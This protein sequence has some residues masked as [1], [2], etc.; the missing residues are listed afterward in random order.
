MAREHLT[1][2]RA[3]VTVLL[4]GVYYCDTVTGGSMRFPE[5]ASEE[6]S[7][8]G[9][10][11]DE[12]LS[13]SRAGRNLRLSVGGKDLVEPLA[14]GSDP[15]FK[16]LSAGPGKETEARSYVASKLCSLGLAKCGEERHG[17]GSGGQYGL[18]NIRDVTLV[19][20]VALRPVGEPI[21]AI[22]LEKQPFAPTT[23][24][25]KYM[26]SGFGNYGSENQNFPNYNSQQGG[27][28][29]SSHQDCT[30]VSINQCN[31]YDIINNQV[32]SGTGNLGVISGIGQPH[33]GNV[34]AGIDPRS[35]KSSIES[36]A[37]VV[38]AAVEPLSRSVRSE[39]V[40]ADEGTVTTNLTSSEHIATREKREAANFNSDPRIVN[41]AYRSRCY[42]DHLVCCRNPIK[43][44]SSSYPIGGG[45]S[46]PSGGS[47]S[48]YPIGGSSNYPSHGGSSYPN[49]DYN[50]PQQSYP[51]KPVTNE[52]YPA[53]GSS[54]NNGI[55]GKRNSNGIN[56][57]VVTGNYGGNSAEFGEYPWYTHRSTMHLMIIIFHFV[58]SVNKL[59]N[60]IVQASSS[61]EEGRVQQRL[62]LWSI[63]CRQQA[64]AHC[65]P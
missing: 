33:F 35:K 2:V 45:S 4:L 52:Y 65:C 11:I 51:Q 14:L 55:C 48:S 64:F 43:S 58:A 20:P 5:S 39:T 42:D 54:G 22:P 37:T 29:S 57:R 60:Y 61:L 49:T 59:V 31:S 34:G 53:T 26:N 47:G 41:G 13:A 1:V 28:I 18:T 8:A 6:T 27:I 38:E 15:E 25:G 46:Y 3:M 30:C 44:P 32:A 9:K 16:E 17:G 62:C 56:G 21:A 50:R 12:I 40:G 7:E 19:Q 23:L 36:N 10:V 24:H 63:N